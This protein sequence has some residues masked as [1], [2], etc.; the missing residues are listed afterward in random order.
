MVDG[1]V[2]RVMQTIG[3][4][5]AKPAKKSTDETPLVREDSLGTSVELKLSLRTRLARHACAQSVERSISSSGPSAL[6]TDP[7]WCCHRTG[8]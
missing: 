5:P 6:L 2:V 3:S 7:A 8:G 4:W 1:N